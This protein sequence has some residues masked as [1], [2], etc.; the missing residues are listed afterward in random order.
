M[1]CAFFSR[2]CHF[3]SVH[4]VIKT[5]G[6]QSVTLVFYFQR[7]KRTTFTINRSS[8]SPSKSLIHKKVG[9]SF[10]ICNIPCKISVGVWLLC[11]HSCWR[12]DWCRHCPKLVTPTSNGFSEIRCG[13]GDFHCCQLKILSFI[14]RRNH[15]PQHRRS[16]DHDVGTEIQEVKPVNKWR[17]QF[18]ALVSNW[19]YLLRTWCVWVK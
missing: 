13:G 12:L 15:L 3:W 19:K 9:V 10:Y 4:D 1:K 16:V 5:S 17:K 7:R 8:K 6:Q 18:E 2:K 11:C 14:Y